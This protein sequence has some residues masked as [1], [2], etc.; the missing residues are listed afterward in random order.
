MLSDKLSPKHRPGLLPGCCGPSS[1][2]AVVVITGGQHRP[3]DNLDSS[4]SSIRHMRVYIKLQ[5]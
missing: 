2:L 4:S 1:G 5:I 3:A